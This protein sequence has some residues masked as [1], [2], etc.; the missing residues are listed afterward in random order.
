MWENSNK[1]ALIIVKNTCPYCS[2]TLLMNKRTF[3]NHVRWCKKNPR[4][5]ELRESTIRKVKESEEKNNVAKLGE[6]KEFEVEC[7]K[8]GKCFKVIE[9]E[10]LFPSKKKYF[11]SIACRNSHVYTNET[12]QKISESLKRYSQEHGKTRIQDTL[13]KERK[14]VYC[15]KSFHS[16]KPHQKYCSTECWNNAR[17]KK[18]YNDRF[19]HTNND[20]EKAKIIYNIYRKQ[21]AFNFSL[22]EFPDEFDF[23]LIKE[24]GWYQ[25]KN[26]G[27]NL[28]GVSRDHMFSISRGFEDMIDPYYISHPANCQLLKHKD[29][30]TKHSNCSISKDILIKRVSDWNKKYGFYE[31]KINY[32][33]LTEYGLK[34]DTIDGGILIS[35]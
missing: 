11:C 22:N 14:C 16:Y 31:N 25:A 20:I 2:E 19:N 28:F 18:Y 12:K 32:A 23:S 29:N 24:N 3:A 17:I 27:N 10:K 7:C 6:K 34:Y 4:Y 9:R 30:A 5:D 13:L 15:G 8:C 33:L 21:C 1:N 26:H 35:G